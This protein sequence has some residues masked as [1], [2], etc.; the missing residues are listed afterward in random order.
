MKKRSRLIIVLLILIFFI[1]HF[2]FGTS[3]TGK[4]A[5]IT[6]RILF[7]LYEPLVDGFNSVKSYF[8][9]LGHDYIFLVQA[10]K[11][12][13]IL[14]QTVELLRVQNHSLRQL[15]QHKNA[16][17]KAQLSYTFLHKQLKFL[18]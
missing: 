6:D 11:E 13:K 1:T 4:E 5:F 9:E 17:S 15:V 2:L 14:K 12:N 7:V 18:I 10:K 8:S 16:N 3:R